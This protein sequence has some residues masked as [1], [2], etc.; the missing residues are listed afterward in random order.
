[1]KNNALIQPKSLNG[2]RKYGHGTTGIRV[3]PD[4]STAM[5]L[6]L[7]PCG[8]HDRKHSSTCN[9]PHRPIISQQFFVFFPNCHAST[10]IA[11]SPLGQ[12]VTFPSIRAVCARPTG[13][14]RQLPVLSP[15]PRTMHLSPPLDDQCQP[16]I[17]AADV[18]CE[19]CIVSSSTLHAVNSTQTDNP[20]FLAS[21][22]NRSR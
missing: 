1:M 21:C 3:I 8:L 10:N 16:D 19:H 2:D 17:S 18:T 7:H 15:R 12:Y 22:C 9:H 20:S 5:L 13:W 11:K 6:L 14:C 4:Y